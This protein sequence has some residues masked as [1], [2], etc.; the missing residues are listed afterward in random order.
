M[1]RAFKQE[2][3]QG[4]PEDDDEDGINSPETAGARVQAAKALLTATPSRPFF[5]RGFYW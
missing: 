2:W 3:D 5:P 4:D 1:D